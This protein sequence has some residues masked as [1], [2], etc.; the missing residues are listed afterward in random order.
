LFL[1]GTARAGIAASFIEGRRALR[2]AGGDELAATTGGFIE[3][4]KVTYGKSAPAA[5]E[6]SEG[7]SAK[8]LSRF[9]GEKRV[10]G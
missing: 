7:D 10:V 6:W 1:F 9:F 4:E 3:S 8:C 5:G 2:P